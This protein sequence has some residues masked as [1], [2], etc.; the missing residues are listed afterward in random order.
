MSTDV[1]PKEETESQTPYNGF[2]QPQQCICNIPDEFKSEMMKEFPDFMDYLKTQKSYEEIKAS[3]L[4]R[5]QFS[6]STEAK[7]ALNLPT[8][9][10][11][12]INVEYAPVGWEEYFDEYYDDLM[13]AVDAAN[14]HIAA[15][16]N[17][18]P[19][20]SKIFRAFEVIKP[21]NVRVVIIGQDPYHM[22]KSGS[23]IANGL[24]FSCNGDAQPSLKTIFSEIRST[25]GREP[26]TTDLE[27][28]S[29]QGVLLLNTSLTVN[30]GKAGSHGTIW[31]SFIRGVLTML[32][33]R[34]TFCFLCLWGNEAKKLATGK[35]K[36]P[37]NSK[38][39]R[40]LEAGHPSPL[41]TAHPFKGCGHF[42]IINDHFS[43]RGECAIDWTGE[44]FFEMAE[45]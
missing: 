11:Q 10:R 13:R 43:S 14:E 45:P 34:T 29:E 27:F 42:K 2:A 20:P 23:P 18:F 19:E 37:F 28:W 22:K 24:A 15:G 39:V 9:T 21:E 41:N 31:K 12:Y 30:E 8:K 32:F 4:G 25:E 1:V 5:S 38:K 33:E 36:I 3:V 44:Y 6:I 40:V 16:K 7:F 17:V 35:D 26:M